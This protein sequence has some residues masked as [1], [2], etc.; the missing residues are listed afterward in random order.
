MA[1]AAQASTAPEDAQSRQWGHVG[2]P[3]DPAPTN[4]KKA[5]E[6]Q[7]Q[8]QSNKKK[9]NRQEKREKKRNK[10]KI[11]EKPDEG[12]QHPTTENNSNTES[13]P[14]DPTPNIHPPTL[15]PP[16]P[17]PTLPPLLDP[18]IT[19]QDDEED[20]QPIHW[21]HRPLTTGP[22]RRAAQQHIRNL[23]ITEAVNQATAEIHTNSTTA[24]IAQGSQKTHQRNPQVPPATHSRGRRGSTAATIATTKASSNADWNEITG[25]A[26]IHGNQKGH[27]QNH[28]R[29]PANHTRSPPG[30]GNQKAHWQNHHKSPANHTKSRPGA[31]NATSSNT[32]KNRNASQPSRHTYAANNPANLSQGNQNPPQQ[33]HHVAPSQPSTTLQQNEL[34]PQIFSTPEDST[35]GLDPTYPE[36]IQQH[37]SQ[38]STA[39]IP[40]DHHFG[41]PLTIHKPP[42]T[43]RLELGNVDNIA[44]SKAAH[45][46]RFLI[47][48]M[49]QYIPDLYM[50]TE[51][52]LNLPRVPAGDSW[53]ERTRGILPRQTYQLAY[54]RHDIQNQHPY[55]PG[56]TGM[57]ALHEAQPRVVEKGVDDS[58][59]GRWTW[60]RIQGKHGHFTRVLSAYRPCKSTATLGTVYRQQLTYWSSKGEFACPLDL[61]D[62]HLEALLGEWKE[63][64][65]HIVVG[66]DANEDIRTGKIQKMLTKKIY[67]RDAILDLHSN[68]IPRLKPVT[69]TPKESQLTESSS[70]TAYSQQQVDIP[71]MVKQQAPIT[72]PF[73][74]T[75]HSL[76][77]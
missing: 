4:T 64:G 6:N 9:R 41:N 2:L 15:P 47:D 74:S 10:Q 30:D 48:Q 32:H 22:V 18:H 75:S 45:S 14:Q 44:A 3:P 7:L 54:N 13:K 35:T 40:L 23:K 26:N 55:L 39:T 56:G 21:R 62:K 31:S 46:S 28:L 60:M 49:M 29:A 53:A 77:C 12:L 33:S 63:S 27:R 38:G 51:M 52:G 17:P 61:F 67:L 43:I 69:R 50:I 16:Q 25:G 66:I 24:A 20:L 71:P 42:N 57:I 59:L 72:E 8:R 65:D 19:R 36:W 37:L 5:K 68:M 73:G 76:Q 58:G 11:K 70:P 34:T 1:P